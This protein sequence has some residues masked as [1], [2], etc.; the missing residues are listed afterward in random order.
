M[1]M[2]KNLS[3]LEKGRIIVAHGVRY[4]DI[5]FHRDGTVSGILHGEGRRYE[6][7]TNKGGRR[8]IG[9]A[10]ELLARIEAE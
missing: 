5:T 7:R 4:Y 8:L 3:N 1:V 6:V 10:V 9:R 2:G